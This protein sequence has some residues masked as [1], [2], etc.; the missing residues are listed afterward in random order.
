M[1]VI[2]A[3]DL[4]G[5][6]VVRLVEGD[7]SRETVYSD[8]PVATAV[9]FEELGATWIHVVD[10]DAAFG[11]G[12]N[13]DTIR[14]MSARVSAQLQVGGGLRS[15]EAI[16]AAFQIGAARVVL[17][18]N[19]I[20]QRFLRSAIERHGDR[21]VVALDIRDQ[22]V[23]LHGWQEQGPSVEQLVS[24]LERAG[25]ARYL[26]TSIASDGRL[27]GPDLDLY[28]RVLGLTERPVIASGGISSVEDLRALS[29]LGVEGAVVGKALYEGALDLPDALQVGSP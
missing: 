19:A 11:A 20:D 25:V 18:T 23:M 8:D 7:P 1:I 28:R 3:I 5:G 17:G 12:S 15:A 21:I 10:L 6:K 22:R 26:V 29:D 24:H 4:R 2:P 9:R 27:E 13:G 16:G 14:R